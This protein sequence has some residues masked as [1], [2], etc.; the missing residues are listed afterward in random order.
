M[1]VATAATNGGGG[2]VRSREGERAEG[3]RDGGRSGRGAREVRGISRGSGKR[4]ERQEEVEAGGGVRARAR[5][6]ADVLLAREKDDTG[7][8][9]GGLGRSS[10]AG[11]AAR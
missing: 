5:R 9:G 10:W 7:G 6:H 1:A 4:A 2:C 8:N 11:W 3:D